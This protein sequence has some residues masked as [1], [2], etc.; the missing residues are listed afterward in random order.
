MTL[1]YFKRLLVLLLLAGGQ[2]YAQKAIP[3]MDALKLITKE[4]K[5]DFVYDPQVMKKKTTTYDLSH[6][7]GKS[8]EDVLKG[9]L[10][11][12][13]LVFL[14]VK[15]NYYTVVEKDRVGE[16][17]L[18]SKK[19]TDDADKTLSQPAQ[20]IKVSG[21]VRDNNNQ[22]IPNAMIQEKGTS[23]GMM[24][25]E[26]GTFSITVSGPA[27]VLVFSSIGFTPVEEVVGDRTSLNI[28]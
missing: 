5:A 7:S 8:L 22:L 27:A 26:D 15:P 6:L 2:L 3:V 25:K 9:V 21:Q 13:E 23:N 28:V 10:Y 11:P 18:P 24:S 20:K 19:L 1:R 12:N 17:Q 14:Y 16:Y 4:F